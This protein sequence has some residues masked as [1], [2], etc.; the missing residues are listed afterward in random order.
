M[1]TQSFATYYC[2][3]SSDNQSISGSPLASFDTKDE[4]IQWI[5][6]NTGVSFQDL[7]SFEHYYQGIW[8]YNQPYAIYLCNTQITPSSTPVNQPVIP[9]TQPTPT[10]STT[11]P[12]STGDCWQ[13]TYDGITTKYPSQSQAAQALLDIAVSG[14]MKGLNVN[15]W[16]YEFT[17]F[18]S[19]TATGWGKGAD[20]KKCD[21][22][23]T[24]TPS[25]IPTTPIVPI[26]LQ[27]ITKPVLTDPEL[28]IAQ[29]WYID[30]DCPDMNIDCC[31][32]I[33]DCQNAINE[34]QE[35][36]KDILLTNLNLV[37]KNIANY[38]TTI[39]QVFDNKLTNIENTINNISSTVV[40]N[41]DSKLQI[42]EDEIKNIFN[43]Y[44]IPH[45]TVL[46]KEPETC[47]PERIIFNDIHPRI[48]IGTL[49][50]SN[51]GE[52]EVKHDKILDE[53]C[54]QPQ[55]FIIKFDDGQ[56]AAIIAA[57]KSIV[58]VITHNHT[59]IDK[60]DNVICEEEYPSEGSYEF[61]TCFDKDQQLKDDRI[62][63]PSR[64]KE[65]QAARA[66]KQQSLIQEDM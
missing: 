8:F 5:S 37:E 54:E 50:Q 64:F 21:V 60:A 27:P 3:A 15:S 66:T 1:A 41:N 28:C 48:R 20:V 61:S 53:C 30:L 56:L 23:T 52:V 63:N 39:S 13:I 4:A 36:I 22:T 24:P 43:T 51:D 47:C 34:I 31:K 18:P 14:G 40:M 45:E 33:D 38:L 12:V 2:I 59:K 44:G 9:S 35:T 58:P 42:I 26:P 46:Q 16:D 49:P 25:P 19:F 55:P 29:D 62:D 6:D 17:N 7:Q 11:P 57:I 10:P 32:G 65:F